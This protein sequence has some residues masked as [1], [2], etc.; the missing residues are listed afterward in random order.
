MWV[1]LNVD[2]DKYKYIFISNWNESSRAREL[3]EIHVAIES[4]YVPASTHYMNELLALQ[5]AS[6][7]HNLCVCMWMFFQIIVKI[8]STLPRGFILQKKISNI[9]N[10]MCD[11]STTCRCTMV[12]LYIHVFCMAAVLNF[13]LITWPIVCFYTS[14][15][16]M[17][18]S[19]QYLGLRVKTYKINTRTNTLLG[20][21]LNHLPRKL[22]AF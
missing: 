22:I 15:Q 9:Y 6:H 13:Q 2:F 7:Y 20:F 16:N 14:P 21:R 11:N 12:F 17:H 10:C 8:N 5:N 4:A 1:N 19:S 18:L 3:V